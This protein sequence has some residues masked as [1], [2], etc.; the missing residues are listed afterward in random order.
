MGTGERRRG[1]VLTLAGYLEA[2]GVAV[3]LPGPPMPHTPVL[4][5]RPRTR[6]GASWSGAADVDEGGR[7]RAPQ[8]PARRAGLHDVRQ[9]GRHEV[10]E[11]FV[12]RRLL[13]VD[14]NLLEVTH[15]ALLTGWPRLARWLADDAAGRAVRR[16]L[17]P[18][19][20]A[21]A[22]AGRPPEELYRGARLAGALDWASDAGTDVTPLEREF[23]DASRARTDAE[24]TEARD[25]A[26][27][28]ADGRRRTRRLAVGLAAVL[29][30]ALVAAGLAV[31]SQRQA[32]EAS[33]IADAN[34]LAALSTTVGGLDL[35]LLLAAQAVRLADTPE[36]QDGLLTALSAQGRADRV[37]GFEGYP[38]R[39]NLTDGGSDPVLRHRHPHGLG[40]RPGHPTADA[41]RC[42]HGPRGR[43]GPGGL[44]HRRTI[45]DRRR[46]AGG[47]PERGRRHLGAYGRDR[48]LVPAD[49]GG[50]GPG[51]PPAGRRVQHRRSRGSISSWRSR[52][53]SGR[54]LHRGGVSR[55]SPPQTAPCER[56]GSGASS[57]LPSRRWAASSTADQ[58]CC[59]TAPDPPAPWSST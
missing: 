8:G 9:A 5:A 11:A 53:T 14:G 20:R 31:T 55:T 30:A 6:R 49:R 37:I 46:A 39:L 59:G 45:A 50:L 15:E 29:V 4:T 2:G 43:E 12:S 23:L 52:T 42:L 19:A 3:A 38:Y 35:S 16:H 13:S 18:A 27:R 58:P 40:G 41:R 22:D 24:L 26:R 57:R 1:G 28:E 34:R 33:L 21:W 17:A 25:R 51:W 54:T 10:I 32:Q 7:V 56:P 44:A 48:W 47:R 36:T